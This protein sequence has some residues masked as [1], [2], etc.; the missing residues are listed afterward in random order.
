MVQQN[1]EEEFTKSKNP[2][3]DG[4]PPSRERISAENLRAIGKSFDLK[5]QKMTQKLGKI[6]VGYSWKFHFCH[7]IEPRVQVTC[8]EK[9]HSFLISKIY[10][11]ER[12]SSEKKKTMRREDWRKA[13]NIWGKNKFNYIVV[14]GKGRNSVPYHN[15]TQEFVPMKRSQ[16]SSSLNF[17]WRWKQ[18]L[19]VSSG[20]T[21]Y[22]WDKNS[23][24]DPWKSGSMR[25]FQVWIWEERSMIWWFP[26]VVLISELRESRVTYGSEDSGELSLRDACLGKPKSKNKRSFIPSNV[27]SRWKRRQWKRNDRRWKRR[28]TRTKGKESP[29]CCIDGHPPHPRVQV[30]PRESSQEQSQVWKLSS[31]DE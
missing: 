19:V 6:F 23:S 9:N 12:N 31:P 3:W 21:A 10:I 4:N 16:E 30:H 13:K 18:A 11:I 2:L 24:S 14:A 5:N 1:Y 20:G 8:R 22:L 26:N 15:F 28:H 27:I 29:L 7:H 25:H 17:L